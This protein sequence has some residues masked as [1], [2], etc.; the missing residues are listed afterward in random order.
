M[1]GNFETLKVKLEDGIIFLSVNRPDKLNALNTQVLMEL[2]SFFESLKNNKEAHSILFSGEGEKAFIAGADIKGM[3][4][5]NPSEAR[6]FAR[7][8]QE[9]SLMFENS[10]LP[11]LAA[12]D[13]FALGG[14]CEMAMSCDILYATEKSVFGQPEINLG[15]IPGFGGT[16]RLGRYVGRARAKE[17]IYTG[18]NF[19]ASQALDWGLISKMFSS[20]DELMGESIKILKVI[21]S[22][23]SVIMK[24]CKDS[25]NQGEG[26]VM[27]KALEVERQCF[28]S[29][30]DT[31]DTK[32]GLSAFVEKRAP[33][34]K[35]E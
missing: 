1:Q 28:M 15:L 12:I 23:S 6:E 24:K 34:F 20:R 19:K 3:L 27:S 13:G 35:G 33:H 31:Y 14:G 25:I 32:E 26:L 4:T 11:I 8:G 30:F 2:K 17:L 29:V 7:L 9:V 10:P 21:G 16:Q 18:A 5:M 22:K